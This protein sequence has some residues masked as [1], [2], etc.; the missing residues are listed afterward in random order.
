MWF[1]NKTCESFR[2]R[3]VFRTLL[4]IFQYPFM[5]TSRRLTRRT[6]LA[7]P[8]NEA[9]FTWIWRNNYW[10]S[11]ESVS[12]TGST[13][14]YTAN[15]RDK[16]PSLFGKHGIKSVF[17]AP[18]GDFNWMRELT[19]TLDIDYTGADIV[20]PLIDSLN[21]Q[22]GGPRKKFIHLD[23]TSGSL[24]K[25]DLMICRDCLF[26]LS[27]ADTRAVLENFVSSGTPYI[28]TTT[29]KDDGTFTNFDIKTGFYRRINLF[30]PPYSLP[31]ATLA[32]IEDWVAP[33]PE[34]EMCLWSREQ[35]TN[36][37]EGS[38]W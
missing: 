28:L 16:L 13:L 30:A 2:R 15:L 12:G 33:D 31:T 23:L 20:G 19:R 17:D 37:L 4:K 14:G 11:K 22:H 36:A 34:R 18:C 25:A 27:Y 8:S 1:M 24:P 21:K 7:I 32:R 38:N 29:H 26:H 9:R 10:R 6:L 5:A 35:I 3:G